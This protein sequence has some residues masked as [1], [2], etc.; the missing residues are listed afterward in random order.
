MMDWN[1]C[2]TA[3]LLNQRSGAVGS[4]ASRGPVSEVRPQVESLRPQ[5]AASSRNGRRRKRQKICD[6]VLTGEKG[7]AYKTPIDAA[8]DMPAAP[9]ASSEMPG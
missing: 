8:D 5:G 9:N 2:G 1:Q 7:R 6:G 4:G 3:L